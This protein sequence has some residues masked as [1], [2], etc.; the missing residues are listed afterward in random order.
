VAVYFALSDTPRGALLSGAAVSA[1]VLIRPNLAPLAGVMAL[2]ILASPGPRIRHA[3]WFAA[4]VIPGC[5]L[6]AA[7]N[8]WLYGSPL[9]SGYG[10]LDTLFSLANIRTNL[11]RY[12]G[13]LVE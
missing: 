2:W 5:L 8:A 10:G 6:V 1:A 12:G 3:M 11:G 4:G 7:V 9:S 13:W